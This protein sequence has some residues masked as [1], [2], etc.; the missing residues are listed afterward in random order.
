MEITRTIEEEWRR[1][2]ARSLPT[3]LF[4]QPRRRGETQARAPFARVNQREPKRLIPPRVIQIE[5]QCAFGQR[6]AVRGWE[7]LGISRLRHAQVFLRFFVSGIA[8]QRFIELD[9]SLGDL[10]LGQVHS[11]QTIVGNC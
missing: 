9:D 1:Q 5:M 3:E 7:N 2:I 8:P 4:D 6:L 10:A 11:A